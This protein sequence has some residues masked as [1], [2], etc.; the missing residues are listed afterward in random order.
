MFWTAA[1]KPVFVHIGL[2]KTATTT[3]QRKYFSGTPAINYLGKKRVT[4]ELRTQNIAL[5]RHPARLYDPAEA[6]RVF[7]KHLA[8]RGV[9]VFSEEDLTSYNFLHPREQGTRIK[10]LFRNPRIIYVTRKPLEW[11]KSFYFFRLSTYDPGTFDGINPWLDAQL[12]DPDPES[13]LA[14]LRFT[15]TFRAFHDGAGR[16]PFLILPYEMMAKDTDA[17]LAKIEAFMGLNGELRQLR[18]LPDNHKMKKRKSKNRITLHQANFIRTLSLYHTDHTRFME[19][20]ARFAAVG[21]AKL[22]RRFEALREAEGIGPEH[23]FFLFGK[24]ERRIAPAVE[25]DG[26]LRALLS[27][28]DDYEIR[29]DL[30]K[31]FTEI[32]ARETSILRREYDT[33]LTQFG[34]D[35]A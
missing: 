30:Q 25:A 6:R 13:K 22:Q 10:Q 29:P 3:L 2:A 24:V 32:E 18:D 4:T 8:M 21:N 15:E 16:P 27:E 12:S 19:R 35:S 17:F 20:A 33:D 14:R 7:Q 31:R 5:T 34:Y 1:E 23:W 11:A 28:P 9:A 26:E